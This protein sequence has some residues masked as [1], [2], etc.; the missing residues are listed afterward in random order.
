MTPHMF[1]DF[2]NSELYDGRGNLDDRLL[3][4]SWRGA[5]LERWGMGRFAPLDETALDVLVDLRSAIRAIAETLRA[6]RRPAPRHL[7]VLNEALAANPV[8][9]ELRGRGDSVELSEV[10]LARSGSQAVA[11]AIALSAARFLADGESDRLKMCDNPGC[12]WVFHDDTKNR[13][14]RWCGPCGNVDKVRRFRERQ[15]VERSHDAASRRRVPD[16]VRGGRG[17]HQTDVP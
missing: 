10:P 9:F 7:K 4:D 16:P 17:R 6:G 2:A 12:R 5:F 14:R 11:G 1:I 13:S 3:D 15:L 8:R